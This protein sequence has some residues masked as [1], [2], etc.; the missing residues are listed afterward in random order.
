[1]VE[2]SSRCPWPCREESECAWAGCVNECAGARTPG[3]RGTQA[4]PQEAR[5]GSPRNCL[6]S[7]STRTW[8][9][10]RSS[11]AQPHTLV[12]KDLSVHPRLSRRGPDWMGLEGL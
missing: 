10:T 4:E 6:W 9:L 1:M 7:G 12:F 11:S 5:A 3:L 2:L 8:G